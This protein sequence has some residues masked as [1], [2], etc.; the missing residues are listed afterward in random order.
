MPAFDLPQQPTPFIGREHEID[1]LLTLLDD[2][3]CRLLTLVGPG[4]IGKSRLALVLAELSRE[5]YRDGVYFVAL[6]DWSSPADIVSAIWESI[7]YQVHT[8]GDPSKELFAFLS[9]RALLLVLDNMEH[10][11]AGGILISELLASASDVKLLVTSRERLNLLEETTFEVSGLPYPM[12]SELYPTDIDR[13][14][15]VQLF[16]QR[17]RWAYPGFRLA[18]ELSAVIRICR[19]TEGM[20]LALEMAATWTRVLTCDEIA[21]EIEHN[22]DILELPARNVPLRHRTM[23]AVLDHSWSILSEQQ[24]DVL[25]RLSVF[26]GGFTREAA[27]TVA[28][29][30]LHDLSALLDRSWLRWNRDEKRYEIHELLRQFAEE[31]LER[32]AEQGV[33][34]RAAHTHYYLDLLHQHELKLH[35]HQ[36][37]AT[38]LELEKE[39]DNIRTAW[40][41]AIDE[42]DLAAIQKGAHAYY[43]LNDMR[44]RYQEALDAA[45]LA[46]RHLTSTPATEQRDFTLA[47]IHNAAGGIL[48]RMGRFSEARAA[49]E[50]SIRLFQFTGR[51]PLPGFGTEP[52]IVL[53]LLTSTNGDFG[54]AVLLGEAALSRIDRQND[55]LNSGFALYVLANAT[56]SLGQFNTALGYANQAY[57]ISDEVGD[58]WFRSYILI[59]LGNIARA[60]DRYDQAWEYYQASYDCK[61]EFNDVVGMAFAL[62]C[63]ARTAWLQGNYQ[64]ASRLYQR[65]CDLYRE[66]NDPGGLATAIFG[67]GDAAQAAGDRQTSRQ[68]FHQA[69]SLAVDIQWTP[70]ILEI[71]TGIGDLLLNSGD[72]ERA[73]ELLA[74]AVHHPTTELPTLR[75]AEQL[76]ARARTLQP[77]QGYTVTRPVNA[78]DG[79]DITAVSTLDYLRLSQD[80]QM[81][82]LLPRARQPHLDALTTREFEVLVLVAEGLTNQEI[83]DQLVIGVSTVKK[84]ITHIYSKLGASDR[85]N[86]VNRARALG[87]LPSST[88]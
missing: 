30:S 19:L 71:F 24:Q 48:I 7:R 86:A 45:L 64:E 26:R 2:P 68:C 13:Y 31:Q 9:A 53:G 72:V 58:H 5:R 16:A 81:Q 78:I 50:N 3:A 63:I 88:P 61:A 56:Y 83:A 41:R 79:L 87:L 1:T 37:Q 44:G 42:A 25:V 54:E 76:L 69:L 20:P 84:H 21:D 66:V 6:Q 65:G 34:L 18:H 17:A 49:L 70:L 59:V 73:V 57:Q 40:Q 43:D 85:I 80:G 11:L 14:S 46:I 75:R 39:L 15:A 67:L 8:G 52:L 35:S 32:E 22:L 62:N 55:K 74:L 51:R 77:A 10:L 4:G 36:Q 27:Q 82:Q 12:D 33:Q 23:R 29:S 60:T 38:I 28:G 47:I